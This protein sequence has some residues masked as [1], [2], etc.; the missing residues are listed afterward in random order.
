[1]K[2]NVLISVFIAILSG[3]FADS[4]SQ[5]LCATENANNQLLQMDPFYNN[6]NTLIEEQ[7]QEIINNQK[8]SK[9][10]QTSAVLTIPVVVHVVHLG[11]AVGTGTN[12]SDAKIYDAIKGL[13]DRWRNVAGNIN[14]NDLGIEFCLASRDPNGN[15]TTGINR[16]NGSSILNY[17]TYGITQAGCVAAREDSIKNLSRW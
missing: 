17:S 5:E 15:A 3:Q 11:E 16:V 14:S 4:Y 13:N 8:N 7:I 2:I 6:Q 1:M 12:I 10:A 9:V